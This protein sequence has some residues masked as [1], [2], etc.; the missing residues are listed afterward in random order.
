MIKTSDRHKS[1]DLNNKKNNEIKQNGNAM[2]FINEEDNKIIEEMIEENLHKNIKDSQLVKA[3]IPDFSVEH[4]S[5]REVL[6][7]T[8]KH[9][10]SNDN[11]KSSKIVALLRFMRKKQR[12]N[13]IDTHYGIWKKPQCLDVVYQT[14]LGLQDI[15][16][17]WVHISKENVEYNKHYAGVESV[18]YKIMKALYE[19]YGK[20]WL[21]EDGQ[22]TYSTLDFLI[23]PLIDGNLKEEKFEEK[24]TF[25]NEI[26]ESE[27]GGYITHIYPKLNKTKYTISDWPQDKK[28]NILN[29]KTT[30]KKYT[31]ILWRNV[32]DLF[33]NKNK[34][35]SPIAAEIRGVDDGLLSLVTSYVTSTKEELK[36]RFEE[37]EKSIPLNLENNNGE[38]IPLS[39]YFKPLGKEFEEYIKD[40]TRCG[41]EEIFQKLYQFEL[42]RR[43]AKDDGTTPIITA[44]SISSMVTKPVKN[45]KDEIKKLQE[46]CKIIKLMFD[47]FDSVVDKDGI[48]NITQNIGFLSDLYSVIVDNV[49]HACEN[50]QV[51]GTF[52]GTDMSYSTPVAFELNDIGN[53]V[54]L[55]VKEYSKIV[56][57]KTKWRKDAS[58]LSPEENK[59]KDIYDYQGSFKGRSLAGRKNHWG[60]WFKPL[61]DYFIENGIIVVKDPKRFYSKPE[62]V[63]LIISDEYTT[64]DGKYIS[65][66]EAWNGNKYQGDHWGISYKNGGFTVLW[67]GKG[68]GATQNKQKSSKNA[69][70]YIGTMA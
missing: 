56:A 50:Y 67:N 2:K 66:T 17:M 14:S 9:T 59:L 1:K 20:H 53:F 18:D 48:K 30:I 55:F 54:E 42:K 21:G 8:E 6:E 15:D 36:N 35:S 61:K 7:T 27:G 65:P 24:I 68:L 39:K 13:S 62:V 33:K 38:F 60:G 58:S 26:P 63:A 22:Q 45:Y 49:E 31:K 69:D 23:R 70:E 3:A 16:M 12:G 5:V 32:S 52:N 51:S 40:N 10:K 37:H 19:K 28:D 47:G 41:N 43:N 57:A 34:N 44:D 64:F 46:H 11:K 29:K 25:T 4:P